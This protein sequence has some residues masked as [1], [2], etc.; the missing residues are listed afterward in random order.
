MT[1][2]SLLLNIIVFVTPLNENLFKQETKKQVIIFNKELS[3]T[4]VQD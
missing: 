2:I 1:Y 4:K 3:C